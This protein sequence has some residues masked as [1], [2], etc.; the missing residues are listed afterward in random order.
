M[1]GNNG[2]FA[3]QKRVLNRGQVEE[4]GKVV[5]RSL[6]QQKQALYDEIAPEE[7]CRKEEDWERTFRGC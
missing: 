7:D 6:T 1:G 4:I 2:V 3:R 5:T